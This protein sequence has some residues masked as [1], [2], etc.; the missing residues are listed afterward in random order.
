MTIT[1]VHPSRLNP[2][3][4]QVISEIL[5]LHR[6]SDYSLITFETLNPISDNKAN[7]QLETAIQTGNHDDDIF[8]IG[9][10]SAGTNWGGF[11]AWI[12]TLKEVTLGEN[13]PLVRFYWLNEFFDTCTLEGVLPEE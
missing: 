10:G 4:E 2:D 7:A 1:V 8:I 12:R 5:R 9:V 11:K 6:V 3:E 13:K